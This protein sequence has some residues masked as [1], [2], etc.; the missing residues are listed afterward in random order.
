MTE[1]SASAFFS[2]KDEAEYQMTETVGHL[3]DHLEAKVIDEQ[4]N[5]VPFGTSGELCV[6]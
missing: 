2:L 6:R 1:L 3:Q 5:V 4:G